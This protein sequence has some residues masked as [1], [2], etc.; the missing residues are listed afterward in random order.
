VA[1][2]QGDY[3]FPDEMVIPLV[4]NSFTDNAALKV[5]DLKTRDRKSKKKG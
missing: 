5:L 4:I 1:A 3:D 2:T